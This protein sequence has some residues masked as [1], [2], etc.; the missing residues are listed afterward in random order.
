MDLSG[1]VQEMVKRGIAVLS[2][3]SGEAGC[4]DP[5]LVANAV[6]FRVLP[7]GEARPRDVFLFTFGNHAAWAAG[8]PAVTACRTAWSARVATGEEGVWELDV[9]PFRLFGAGW[10]PTLRELLRQ[11]VTVAAGNGGLP[12][13]GFPAE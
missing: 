13:G 7:P 11:A 2:A 3:T 12:G 4:D 6:H 10:S 9:S 8:G 1:L 5:D